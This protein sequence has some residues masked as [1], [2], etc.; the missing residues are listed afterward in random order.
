MKE[1][2]QLKDFNYCLHVKN[3]EWT[4]K[5]IE[6]GWGYVVG[7]ETNN[8]YRII[9]IPRKAPLGRSKRR[10]KDYVCNSAIKES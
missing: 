3:G 9:G 4:I 7:T 8:T 6:M 5:E 1:M 10:Q 2:L